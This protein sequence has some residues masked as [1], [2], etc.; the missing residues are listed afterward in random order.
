MY[1]EGAGKAGEESSISI[2]EVLCI[3]GLIVCIWFLQVQIELL[4]LRDVKDV[5]KLLHR[6]RPKFL[7]RFYKW[8]FLT[9]RGD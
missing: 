3:L 1:E 9:H 4:W 8:L 2:I 5:D 7:R 6:L